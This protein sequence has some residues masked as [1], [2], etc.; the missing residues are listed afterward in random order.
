MT[1]ARGGENAASQHE[2]EG[3][4]QGP[5]DRPSI[6]LQ[7][8]AGGRSSSSSSSCCCCCCCY[9]CQQWPGFLGGGPSFA[10]LSLVGGLLGAELAVVLL[11][12]LALPERAA[13][14]T[15]LCGVSLS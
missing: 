4:H 13:V 15:Q 11:D 7:P 5:T 10:W 8:K 14:R 12:L 2:G 3:R 1:D 9:S 6:T